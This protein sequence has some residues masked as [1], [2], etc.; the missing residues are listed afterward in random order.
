MRAIEIINLE[1]YR[2]DM[3]DCFDNLNCLSKITKLKFLRISNVHFPQ[4]LD[5]LSNDLRILEWY[6]YSLKSLPSTFK[7]THIFEIEMCNSQLERLWEKDLVLANLGS[8]NL[9]FSKYLTTIPDL[10]SASNLE[11]LNLEGCTNLIELHNSVLLHKRLR[12]LNMKGSTNLRNLGQSSIEMEALEALHLSGC[13][14]LEYIPRFGH[15]MKHLQHL[16]VDGTSIK[17]L[18]DNLGEICNLRNLSVS[19]TSIEE[20]PSSINHLK[21]LRLLHVHG[22]R[23]LSKREG[24]LFAN[25]DTFLS[26]LRE[27]DLSY[28]NLSVVPDGV[29]LLS[30]LIT[31]DLSGN[32]FILLPASIGL[33]SKLRMLYLNNCKRLQ[34]L[35]KL[36]LANEDTDYGPRKRFSYYISGEGL[37]VSK[38]HKTSNNTCPTVSCLNCSKLAENE[39]GT[40][41]AEKI[42]NNYLQLRT[43]YW[44]TPEAVF[45]I[46]GAGSE[47]P[48]G[49]K[50]KRSDEVTILEG[51]WIGVAISAVIAVHHTDAYMEA[52]YMVTVHIHVGEKHW[53]IPVPI[54]FLEAGLENQ[55]V[56]YWMIADD[57]QRIVDTNQRN[58][59]SFSFSMEP[60]DG[61]I[62]VTKFGV[63]F[64]HD[65]DINQ[66]KELEGSTKRA[67]HILFRATLLLPTDLQC[68][69]RA[70]EAD[71]DLNSFDSIIH[72]LTITTMKFILDYREKQHQLDGI[73]RIIKCLIEINQKVLSECIDFPFT[74]TQIYPLV[75]GYYQISRGISELYTEFI[76]LLKDISNSWF[77]VKLAMEQIVAKHRQG[78]YPYKEMVNDLEAVRS[79]RFSDD[80]ITS[81]AYICKQIVS[82][83]SHLNKEIQGN[84]DLKLLEVMAKVS[85]VTIAG[86]FSIVATYMGDKQLLKK[87]KDITLYSMWMQVVQTFS[88]DESYRWFNVRKHFAKPSCD[89]ELCISDFIDSANLLRKFKIKMTKFNSFTNE[90]EPE[91]MTVIEDLQK[92][93][94][95]FTVTI[96]DMCNHAHKYT[97]DIREA[98]IR[99]YPFIAHPTLRVSRCGVSSIRDEDIQLQKKYEDPLSEVIY[100]LYKVTLSLPTDL[101]WY[102]SSCEA[103]TDIHSCHSIIHDHTSS[104]IKTFLE[105]GK[106]QDS[107]YSIRKIFRCLHQNNLEVL[108]KIGEFLKEQE[109][110]QLQ[111]LHV[112]CEMVTHGI[113]YVVIDFVKFL[114]DILDEW[115]RVKVALQK[116]LAESGSGDCTYEE[117]VEQLK[118]LGQAQ[119]LLSLDKFCKSFLYFCDK[120][121]CYYRH[122]LKT[123]I[124]GGNIKEISRVTVNV[125]SVLTVTAAYMGDSRLL[126]NLQDIRLNLSQLINY[127]GTVSEKPGRWLDERG[128]LKNKKYGREMQIWDFY[129]T[130]ILREVL[131]K[132]IQG[133]CTEE[134][135]EEMVTVIDRLG[136]KIDFF[137][138]TIEDMWRDAQ[139][140]EIVSSEP[141]P[142]D[143]YSSPS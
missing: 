122:S 116:I 84:K 54:N 89:M 21:K 79:I 108:S 11:K 50:L 109:H 9:S 28:C 65:E 38:F 66:L 78:T 110:K 102:I 97:L 90:N 1:P 34:S 141:R 13:S 69:I 86:V 16:Y 57:L 134:I 51:P 3:D 105:F 118:I 135:E 39:H 101:P 94:D 36:S 139:E 43:N 72:D 100:I 115:L 2:V 117:M 77:S 137:K 120:A 5:R 53:K 14:N 8:I 4:G 138:D 62:Q 88:S 74:Y 129:G 132:I 20:L 128:R 7:P 56:L 26:G 76:R 37:D 95:N 82:F 60:E 55:L 6:G 63:R 123:V 45:E 131:E 58:S 98:G 67:V 46:V 136:K 47:I 10:T 104:V 87:M 25:L 113:F 73:C 85:S 124:H 31:L 106:Y 44:I 27:L 91:V 133:C 42:L 24:F 126:E 32:D 83:S 125:A 119:S 12:Y 64:I 49:F 96:E 81:F 99:L 68:Y 80:F 33:L 41:L 23:L 15:N 111:H 61:K 142:K 114:K 121:G 30:S 29:C 52:R 143:V 107:L 18:P 130:T 59:F 35:P 93:I 127:S 103:E 112:E 92:N 17:K 19:G 71:T 140:Y 75:Y 22:C 70:C 40:Y 48:S